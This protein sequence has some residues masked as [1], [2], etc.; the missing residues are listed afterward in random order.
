MSHFH[1]EYPLFP[2]QSHGHDS[3]HDVF[4]TIQVRVSLMTGREVQPV[5]PPHLSRQRNPVTL[6]SKKADQRPVCQLETIARTCGICC[7]TGK[8]H[9][10]R[11]PI[12]TGLK[13]KRKTRRAACSRERRDGTRN[14]GAGSAL[15]NLEFGPAGR[16]RDGPFPDA[17]ARAGDA[18]TA[19]A[20][21]P[22]GRKGSLAWRHTLQS[23]L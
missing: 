9:C 7:A 3:S 23:R 10:I 6:R 12:V 21:G 5:P 17:S 11:H 14:T 16:R 22:G 18:D 19:L 4:R 15:R 8:P 1:R 2:T 13:K 20:A